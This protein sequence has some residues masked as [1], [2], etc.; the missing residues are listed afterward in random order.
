MVLS[1]LQ[2]MMPPELLTDMN[3]QPSRLPAAGVYIV[4]RLKTPYEGNENKIFKSSISLK[5]T[6][7][8]SLMVFH[9]TKSSISS[10]NKA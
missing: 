5:W 8:P 9:T 10:D 1:S 7:I 3:E 6:D 4:W 2:H